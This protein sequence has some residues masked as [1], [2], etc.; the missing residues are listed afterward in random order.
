LALTPNP[1]TYR[2]E[3]YGLSQIAEERALVSGAVF[4]SETIRDSYNEIEKK[5]GP[6]LSMPYLPPAKKSYHLNL[7][8]KWI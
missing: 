1:T 6:N 7:A 8:R 3:K 4:M 5:L 2:I